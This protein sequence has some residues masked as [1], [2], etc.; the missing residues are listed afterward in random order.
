MDSTMTKAQ[1]KILMN[2]LI[3]MDSHMSLKIGYVD[4]KSFVHND[5]PVITE[6]AAVVT[7]KLI[8]E[9]YS[10]FVRKDGV[11]IDWLH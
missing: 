10:L 8:D 7:N 2:H 5:V 3:D 4:E 9:G 6:C 11:H 1:I